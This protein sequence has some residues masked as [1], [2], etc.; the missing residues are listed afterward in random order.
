MGIAERKEQERNEIRKK[1]VDAAGLIIEREGLSQLS[2]RKIAAEIE[3]SP[4]LIYHYYKNKEDIIKTIIEDGYRQILSAIMTPLP[5]S[6]TELQR[7]RTMLEIYMWHILK[8]PPFFKEILFLGDGG[9]SERL[10]ILERGIS[11]R[12]GTFMVL[13]QLLA[14]GV[15]KKVLFSENHEVTAQL[16]W[17]YTV[18]LLS[19]MTIETIS[20]EGYVEELVSAHLDFVENMLLKG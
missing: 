15:K 16:I 14:D 5:E 8:M 1:I 12:N 20:N 3:Y 4:S 7:I 9:N 18:G 2:I 11:S 10:R 13:V 17:C 6:L 19:R